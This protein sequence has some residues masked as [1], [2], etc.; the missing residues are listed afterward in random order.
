MKNSFYPVPIIKGEGTDPKVIKTDDGYY[1]ILSPIIYFPTMPVYHSKDLIH[2]KHVGNVIE[3][4]EWCRK[5]HYNEVDDPFGFWAGG[6][7]QYKGRYYCF[8]DYARRAGKYSGDITRDGVSI[9]LS[10]SDAPCGPYSEPKHLITTANGIDPCFFEDD[11][12]DCY[13]I[14]KGN[15]LKNNS[16]VAYPIDIENS[17]ITGE[18]FNIWSGTGGATPE[19]SFVFK[20]N[21]YYYQSLSEGGTC[22]PQHRTTM[23]RALSFKGP[24]EPSPYNP[25]IFQDDRT[26]PV[27]RCGGATFTYT[28]DGRWW[29]VHIG[30]RPIALESGYSITP[31]GREVMLSPMKW[32]DDGW[33]VFDDDYNKPPC[34]EEYLISS[35]KS[36]DFSNGKMHSDWYFVRIPNKELFECT[37]NNLRIFSDGIDFNTKENKSRC[38]IHLSDFYVNIVSKLQPHF[39]D[40]N[41]SAGIT[42]FYNYR[43]YVNISLDGD[44]TIR[45]RSCKHGEETILYSIPYEYESV[46]LSVVIDHGMIR[47]SY[48]FDE[49]SEEIVCEESFRAT[50]VSDEGSAPDPIGC[51]GYNFSSVGIFASGKGT[52]CD[53]SYFKYLKNS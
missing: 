41:G 32:T 47:F 27:Q 16:T 31:L 44:N 29:A 17:K 21:G 43:H 23:A 50:H 15:D 8:V 39:S 30:A 33:L 36:D 10:G 4:E 46:I 6:F 2:W 11:N 35:K 5:M 51:G 14:I 26:A 3:D 52:Y 34:L 48:K 7:F 12:G 20:H 19:G 18:G 53:F 38:F 28:P 42:Y 13:L 45:I 9:F 25:I 24:W 1:C 40:K 49:E 37:K 22:G